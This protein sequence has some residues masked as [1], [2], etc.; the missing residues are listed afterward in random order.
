MYEDI[1][2]VLTTD[3][4]IAFSVVKPLYCSCFQLI[5]L[6][7]FDFRLRRV[8]AGEKGD[9]GW[10]N[11]FST[12]GESNLADKQLYRI[13]PGNDSKS[14]MWNRSDPALPV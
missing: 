9:A 11:R 1:L 2:A 12:A 6:F 7:P 8:A 5:F 10:R 13:A 3:E 14:S 4:A